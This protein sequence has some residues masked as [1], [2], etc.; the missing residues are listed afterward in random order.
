MSTYICLLVVHHSPSTKIYF[1]HD[2]LSRTLGWSLCR[3][4]IPEEKSYELGQCRGKLRLQNAVKAPTPIFMR[5][6]MGPFVWNIETQPF[7]EWQHGI[8]SEIYLMAYPA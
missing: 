4:L 6:L 8:G 3:D 7:T 5:I 2:A 1:G